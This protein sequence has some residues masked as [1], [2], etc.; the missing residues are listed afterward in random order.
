MNVSFHAGSLTR[1]N[2]ME[3]T[4][5]LTLSLVILTIIRL[6]YDVL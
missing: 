4:F 6:Y 2:L 5:V 3:R 1:E